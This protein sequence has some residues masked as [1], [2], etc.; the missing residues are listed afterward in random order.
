MTFDN[1]PKI[2]V[3]AL[4]K[5]FGT[6]S[7]ELLRFLQGNGHATVTSA[8]ASLTKD[9][10]DNV[11]ALW[12]KSVSA[13]EPEPAPAKAETKTSEQGT[14]IGKVTAP[15]V[16]D[17]SDTAGQPEDAAALMLDE[18]TVDSIASGK[19]TRA[20]ATPER[21]EPSPGTAA[22]KSKKKNKKNKTTGSA[23]SKKGGKAGNNKTEKNNKGKK[24]KRNRKTVSSAT[25]AVGGKSKRKQ[26][27]KSKKAKL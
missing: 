11:A 24:D 14:K 3:Y 27:K 23:K 7:A 15:E 5:S 4:A 2:R 1:A 8:S 21:T 12:K 19:P 22:K 18:K 26:N 10:A 6:T 13:A 25:S 17:D 16:N 20:A 9:D